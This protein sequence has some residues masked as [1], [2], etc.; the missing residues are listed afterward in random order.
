MSTPVDDDVD[1]ARLAWERD[2]AAQSGTQAPRLNLSGIAI[3][4]LYGPQDAPRAGYGESL[5]F[6]GQFPLTRGIHASMYRGRPWSQRQIVGLGLPADY[7]RREHAMLAAGSTGAYLSPCNSFMR[8]YDIDQVPAPLIGRSGTPVNTVDDLAEC[9]QGMALDR[10]SLSLG[11]NAPF[12][13]SAML[14]EL[15]RRQ[16]IDW[17][18]LSGT[19]NQSDYLS[20][21]AANHMFFRLSLDA[22]RRLLID[23][24]K[25]MNARAPRWNPLSVVGQ[26]MQEA[27][28]TPVEA[29]AFALSSAIQYA[30][31]LISAGLAPD[32]FLP[33]FSFFFDVS[34]SFFEEIAKFRAGRRLWARIAREQLGAQQPA[35]WR[36]RFHAQTAGVELTRE[37]PL[38]NLTRVTVQAIAAIFGGCQSLHTDAYD[39]AFQAPTSSSARLALNTQTILRDE[40][41][42]DQVI[43]PLGGSTM[44]SV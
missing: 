31:D 35:S 13:L 41:H 14:L 19:T 6:P 2:Y 5:G 4:P 21:A 8:G 1:A 20:L 37:Q 28:A 32:S 3:K 44:S 33:R 43:D 18:R 12:T 16:G 22:S 10:T 24:I 38:N 23:H 15:A 42:F 36:M 9:L 29:M 11:D 30:R 39:E 25:F 34:L 7:N 17:A 40:A 26:H 27:G